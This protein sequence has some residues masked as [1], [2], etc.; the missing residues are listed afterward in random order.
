LKILL[1]LGETIIIPTNPDIKPIIKP[2]HVNKIMFNI[3]IIINAIFII[4]YDINI[5][6]AITR[7]TEK[8]KINIVAQQYAIKMSINYK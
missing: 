6:F 3:I 8:I 5:F 1:I 4:I 2:E 7:N